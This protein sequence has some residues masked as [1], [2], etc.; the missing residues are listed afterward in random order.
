VTDETLPPTE[1]PAGI[2]QIDGTE[3]EYPYRV[4]DFHGEVIRDDLDNVPPFLDQEQ[5]DILTLVL[6]EQL[7]AYELECYPTQVLESVVRDLPDSEY[8]RRSVPE[9]WRPDDE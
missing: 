3:Y 7:E 4:T 9:D 6:I 2:A 5:V 1:T 8:G